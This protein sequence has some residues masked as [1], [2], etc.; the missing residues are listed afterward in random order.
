MCHVKH[1]GTLRGSGEGRP[2]GDLRGVEREDRG[3]RAGC[4]HDPRHAPKEKARSGGGGRDGFRFCDQ[5]CGRFGEFVGPPPRRRASRAC[6]P[7]SSGAGG[8]CAGS[9]PLA[10]RAPGAERA[11]QAAAPGEG[12][13]RRRR[14]GGRPGQAAGEHDRGGRGGGRARR[15]IESAGAARGRS[16]R[17]DRRRGAS[18]GSGADERTRHRRRRVGLLVRGIGRQAAESPRVTTSS[19]AVPLTVGVALAEVAVAGAVPEMT[20][21]PSSGCPRPDVVA[22]AVPTRAP[23]PRSAP[24][25]DV[26]AAAVPARAPAL[27]HRPRGGRG[28]AGRADEGLGPDQGAGRRRGGGRGACEG[29]RGRQGARGRRRA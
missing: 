20:P 22:P 8:Y 25:A 27:S 19:S 23:A 21:A 13:R 28:G 15:P 18:E 6:R 7:R 26:D 4:A 10:V 16:G 11:V 5:D 17:G 12:A 3:A 24:E 14:R 2:R 29:S 9:R 1:R